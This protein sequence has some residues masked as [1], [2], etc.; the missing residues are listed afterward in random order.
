MA[1]AMRN[2][3]EAFFKYASG[4]KRSLSLLGQEPPE[5]G[6]LHRRTYMGVVQYGQI[7]ESTC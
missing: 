3:E 4:S 5:E 7:C 2:A 1:V 6:A